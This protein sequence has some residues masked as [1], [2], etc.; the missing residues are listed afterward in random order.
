MRFS[1]EQ[2]VE[3]LLSA[4]QSEVV[5]VPDDLGEETENEPEPPCPVFGKPFPRGSA[6]AMISAAYARLVAR[7]RVG[8]PRQ[9]SDCPV[10]PAAS[11][12]MIA[13]IR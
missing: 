13:S 3:Y 7:G 5:L 12:A 11:T 6:P 1:E 2:A 8:F 4:E 9:Q 10:I